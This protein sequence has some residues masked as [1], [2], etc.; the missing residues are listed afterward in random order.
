MRMMSGMSSL[1]AWRMCTKACWAK[2][3]PEPFLVNNSLNKLPSVCAPM[4]CTRFTPC[5]KA[6]KV[7]GNRRLMAFC[8]G[9]SSKKAAAS[10][11]DRLR[12]NWPWALMM[13]ASSLMNTSFSAR[14][15]MATSAATSSIDRLKVLPLSEWPIGLTNTMQFCCSNCLIKVKSMRRMVPV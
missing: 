6:C 8:C 12:T 3:V 7:D 1:M 11:A 13:P 15:P 10:L 9:T 5:C 14:K 4:N 2:D